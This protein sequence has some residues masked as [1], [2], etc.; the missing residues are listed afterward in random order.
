MRKYNIRLLDVVL[1]RKDEK[2]FISKWISRFTGSDFTHAGIINCVGN[3]AVIMAEA[4]KSFVR[5]EYS[6]EQFDKLI[7]DGKVIIRRAK[8]REA[9]IWIDSLRIFSC[10]QKYIGKKYGYLDLLAIALYELTGKRLFKDTAN[11]LICSEAVARILADVEY[12]DLS[13]EM[14]KPFSYITPDDL[15]NSKKLKTVF[16]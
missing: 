6:Y 11:V 16:E 4:Q 5:T 13:Q 12:C 3:N 2:N 8:I 1:F 10:V 9:G 7:D 15:Y 14:K